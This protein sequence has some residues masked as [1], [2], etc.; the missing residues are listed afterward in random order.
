MGNPI[1]KMCAAAFPS[2]A[3]LPVAF[4]LPSRGGVRGGVCNVLSAKKI[5]T[6]PPPLPYKGGERLR[7]VLCGRS[8][9]LK[10]TQKSISDRCSDL[11]CVNSLQEV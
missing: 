2:G 7:V 4:P 1:R 6:P 11:V 10:C 8:D 3:R 5:L 9:F